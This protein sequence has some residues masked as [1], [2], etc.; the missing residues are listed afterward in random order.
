MSSNDERLK[1]L[2]M[3]LNINMKDHQSMVYAPYMTI[4]GQTGKD[5]YFMP[6]IPLNKTNISE[7]LEIIN[8]KKP[9]NDDMIRV[10]F[11]KVDMV[12]VINKMIEIARSNE[13]PLF[14]IQFTSDKDLIDGIITHST[15][16]KFI[17]KKGDNPPTQLVPVS[18]SLEQQD[19]TKVNKLNIN[20][21]R[22]KN[23]KYESSIIVSNVSLDIFPYPRNAVIFELK[24]SVKPLTLKQ[25][26]EK[27][28]INNNIKFI[29]NLL[30]NSEQKFYY[31]GQP[32]FDYE[33]F[34]YSIDKSQRDQSISWDTSPDGN[35]FAVSIRLRIKPLVRVLD[36]KTSK[37]TQ[38]LQGCQ[39]TRAEIIRQWHEIN[40]LAVPAHLDSAGLVDDPEGGGTHSMQLN[41]PRLPENKSLVSTPFA[42]MPTPFA[43]RP[44]AR[45]GKKTK[46][47]RPK[48]KRQSRRYYK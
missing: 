48:R 13:T 11:S 15:T 9:T 10:F 7:A 22:A 46:R 23:F 26:T 30:F 35:I 37:R 45:G 21:V 39:L 36:K 29:V 24:N 38:Q 2:Q 8:K 43:Q 27:G 6:T 4:P 31:K 33:I 20:F 40:D 25:A 28:I 47:R 41:A 34:S 14:P 3:K 44:L 1:I 19:K 18:K 5:I 32:T 16:G 12:N 42:S 17:F